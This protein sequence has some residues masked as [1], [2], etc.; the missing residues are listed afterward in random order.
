[1][2]TQKT[3]IPLCVPPWDEKD[4]IAEGA[5]YDPSIGFYLIQEDAYL[6]NFEQW[7]PAIYNPNLHSPFILPDMLPV[8][9]WEQNL[10]TKLPPHKWESIRKHAY[11]AAGFRCEICGTKGKL[12]AHEKW[13]LINET[14][15]Q[16]LTKIMA[17][18][19]LCHKCHHIGLAKRMG[20]LFDIKNHMKLINNW[21][22]SDF[23]YALL[24]CKEI[25]EQRCD[26]P[27]V[28]DISWIFETGY[29]YV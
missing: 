9:T 15:V 8:T 10:R 17:L 3:I 23:D 18:C 4:V 5:R 16:K 11:K 22:D 21:N 12:E 19:P 27:W 25:W 14:Q 24:E 6:E 2:R 29:L 26:W 7:L 20:L 28:V 13:E 1:M